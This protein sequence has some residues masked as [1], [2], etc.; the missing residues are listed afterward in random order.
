MKL[1]E[2]KKGMLVTYVP[3]HANKNINHKDCENG[4]VS[5]VNSKF[6]FV[7]YN[8]AMCIMITGDE[9]YTSEATAPE[10]LVLR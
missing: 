3:H 7:K 4:V 6:V 1:D 5:S 2:F 10:N 8:N 9:P